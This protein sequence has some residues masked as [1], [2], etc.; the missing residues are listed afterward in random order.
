M[1]LKLL[2]LVALFATVKGFKR[3]HVDFLKH[4][5]GFNDEQVN[6][7]LKHDRATKELMDTLTGL[8]FTDTSLYAI[9]VL[10]HI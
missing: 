9:S 1:S 3:E 8:L 5:V 6:T 10:F 4:N 7:F 2:I